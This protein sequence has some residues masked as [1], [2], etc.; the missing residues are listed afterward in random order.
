MTDVPHWPNR[1]R[2]HTEALAAHGVA[3]DPSLVRT[4]LENSAMARRAMEELLSA[5]HPPTAVVAAQ[6]LI[7]IGTIAVVRARG[8]RHAVAP[9][10]V[11]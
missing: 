5:E 9:G 1:L 8:L 3:Y 10:A 2:G 4:E 6:N 11:A 7:T